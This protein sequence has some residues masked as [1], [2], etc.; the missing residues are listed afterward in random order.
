MYTPDWL[1]THPGPHHTIGDQ[2]MPP[3]ARRGHFTASEE[4]D[5]WAVLPS[6]T[7]PTLVVHGADD[8]VTPA[9]NAPLVAGRVPGARLAL[10]DGARHA[11]FE[12]FR[13][14]ASPLVLDL[15]G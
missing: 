15:P 4:H 11:C 2:D 14:G 10:I 1:A 8:I 7:A 13:A 12:E 3:H 9:A 6:I 5:S